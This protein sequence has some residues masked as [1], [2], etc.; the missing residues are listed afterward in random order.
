[1]A[2]SWRIVY[3][4]SQFKKGVTQ[5]S[6]PKYANLATMR[7]HAFAGLRKGACR[8]GWIRISGAIK[9]FAT[10]NVSDIA[11][12]SGI[13]YSPGPM[14]ARYQFSSASECAATSWAFIHSTLTSTIVS[15]CLIRTSCSKAR[16]FPSSGVAH[17]K[18]GVTYCTPYWN[19]MWG[20]VLSRH[21]RMGLSSSGRVVGLSRNELGDVP[22]SS[23]RRANNSENS[24]KVGSGCYTTPA[25]SGVTC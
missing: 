11:V 16:T 19:L 2:A 24:S 14:V 23:R 8:R 12:V 1:M 3:A 17:V 25:A 15:I 18:D 7:F 4:Q 10:A 13:H 20:S 6:I 22:T 21:A 9:T 5:R